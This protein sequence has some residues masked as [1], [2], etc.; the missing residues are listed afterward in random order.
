LRFLLLE[1]QV[2]QQVD[3]QVEQQVVNTK[4]QTYVS[5]GKTHGV[6]NKQKNSTPKILVNK[7]K[8]DKYISLN[9]NK[10]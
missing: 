10:N 9:K 1:Q 6:M 3:Q 8:N 4:K 5:I 2:E 7:K